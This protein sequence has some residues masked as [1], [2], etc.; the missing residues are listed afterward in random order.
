MDKYL[1]GYAIVQ[2][3]LTAFGL[4]V[5]ESVTPIVEDRLEADGYV[6]RN[7]NSLYK[8]NDTLKNVLLGFIPL[9]YFIKSMKIIR[10]KKR[11]INM[12]ASE[13]LKNGNY[14]DPKDIVPEI[15]V[16]EDAPK[17]DVLVN[18]EARVEFE[19]P[20]KYKARPNKDSIKLYNTYETP[21][22][23]I[24]REAT[25]EDNLE[26]TPYLSNDKVVEKVVKK[27]VTNEDLTNKIVEM[28]VQDLKLLDEKIIDL[29]EIIKREEESE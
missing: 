4:A 24:T 29:M 26:L 10:A 16:I 3:L 27:E 6:K 17:S 21:V 15:Q 28:P 12:L 14:I 22:E 23:Y 20:E 9:Y 25:K 13:E 19:K 8:F 5:I 7:R 11:S 1:M 2:L 18:S